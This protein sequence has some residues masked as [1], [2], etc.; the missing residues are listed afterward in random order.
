VEGWRAGRA[1]PFYVVEEQS[2]EAA[3]A[4]AREFV[5]RHG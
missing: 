4:A 3:L 1:S 2:P 5:Q